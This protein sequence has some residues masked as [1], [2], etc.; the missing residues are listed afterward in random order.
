M[1]DV[2]VKTAGPKMAGPRPAAQETHCGML[3]V[4]RKLVKRRS[5]SVAALEKRAHP[6]RTL[7][8]APHAAVGGLRDFLRAETAE[9]HLRSEQSL[10]GVEAV[11]GQQE[12]YRRFL[13]CMLYAHARWAE[14][15]DHGSRLSGLPV[16]SAA[17]AQ[18]LLK[19][20]A[21]SGEADVEVAHRP[22]LPPAAPELA[23]GASYV[24]EGGAMGAR[25]LLAAARRAHASRAVAY[26][27]LLAANAGERWPRFVTR[28]DAQRLDRERVLRAALAAF[29]SVE[30]AAQGLALSRR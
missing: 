17:I 21:Q 20:L 10:G 18:A 1:L 12:A 23:W 28:L 29:A 5:S 2:Q 15:Q 9:A 3:E 13:R 7:V 30:N 22:G 24:F 25:V 27:D 16:R 19:D 11:R 26:L 14:V 8:A 4:L 6:R